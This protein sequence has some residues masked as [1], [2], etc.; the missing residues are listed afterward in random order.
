MTPPKE[1]RRP[2][3]PTVTDL[4][5]ERLLREMERKQVSQNELAKRVGV[6]QSILS[7]FLRGGGCT[8]STLDKLGRILGGR[9]RFSRGL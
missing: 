5:R 8:S 4:V 9:V 7:E 3:I 1:R 2:R 6:S